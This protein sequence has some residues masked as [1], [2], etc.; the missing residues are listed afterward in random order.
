MRRGLE[1]A[2]PAERRCEV[3]PIV[4][5]NSIIAEG[6]YAIWATKTP[7]QAHEVLSKD[8]VMVTNQRDKETQLAKLVKLD[9]EVRG[10]AGAMEAHVSKSGVPR[11]NDAEAPGRQAAQASAVGPAGEI[12]VEMAQV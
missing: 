4:N 3:V 11:D 6:L 9:E 7:A 10:A 12:A 1:P 5:A 8:D 2:T